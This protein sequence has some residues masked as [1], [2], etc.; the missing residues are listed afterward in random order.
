V[1][2]VRVQPFFSGG[3]YLVELID[4]APEETTDVDER[5]LRTDAEKYKI[6][7]LVQRVATSEL[8]KA[9]ASPPM[10]RNQWPFRDLLEALVM[11]DIA[12]AARERAEA[13]AKARGNHG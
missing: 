2:G 4:R 7:M 9:S 13:E 5:R 10:V 1:G 8:Y 6:D 12:D 11:I 3:G